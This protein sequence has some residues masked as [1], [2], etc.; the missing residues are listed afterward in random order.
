MQLSHAAKTRIQFPLITE[1]LL[2][3]EP[4]T[5]I[6]ATSEKTPFSLIFLNNT[7]EGVAAILKEQNIPYKDHEIKEI[8]GMGYFAPEAIRA[9]D[10]I[11][12]LEH[13]QFTYL[14]DNLERDVAME[15]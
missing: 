2:K 8:S 10:L 12:V 7:K 14:Y 5:I 1:T 15:L 9:D 6:S 3:A 11:K 13:P 4:A